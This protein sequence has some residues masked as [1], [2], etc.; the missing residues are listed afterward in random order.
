MHGFTSK[1]EV[2][3]VQALGTT[4]VLVSPNT[5]DSGTYST[6]SS[7]VSRA[8]REVGNT[9]VKGD[10]IAQ[11]LVRGAVRKMGSPRG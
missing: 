7:E 6:P 11:C 2:P 5:R 9:K 1:R 10:L 3:L 4:L 8:Q